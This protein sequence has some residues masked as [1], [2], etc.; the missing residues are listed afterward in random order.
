MKFHQNFSGNFCESA[1]QAE[2]SNE[3]SNVESKYLK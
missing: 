1:Q 2:N 3:I